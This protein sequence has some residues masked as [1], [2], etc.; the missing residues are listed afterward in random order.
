MNAIA[1]QLVLARYCSSNN[2]GS[3]ENGFLKD[4]DVQIVG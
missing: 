2:H 1:V 3:V 4:E